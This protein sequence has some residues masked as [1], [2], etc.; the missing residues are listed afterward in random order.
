VSL[1]AHPPASA[2][3]TSATFTYTSSVSGA[4]YQCRLVPLG[5]DVP[6]WGPCDPSGASFTDLAE[7]GYRFDVRARDAADEVSYPAAGWFFRVDTTGPTVAFSSAPA[8]NTRSESATFR[9]EPEELITGSMSCTI[10]GKAIGCANGRVKLPRVATGDHTLTVKA[11]DVA[12]NA[13]T[14]SFDWMVDRTR[15]QV[16]ILDAPNKLSSNPVSAFNLWSNEG[17]GF[18]GCSLDGSPAMPCFGAPN[19][20]NLNEGRHTL[21]VWSVDLAY[22]ESPAITYVWKIDRTPPIVSLVGGPTEGSTSGPGEITFGVSQSEKGQLW[23]SLDG[24]EFSK[25]SSPVRFADLSSGPHTFQ[26]YAV[27]AAGNQSVTVKRTWTIA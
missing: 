5:A 12:G 18:F 20:T 4:G 17:P 24:V 8:I 6:L 3:A 23:C 15:P 25:C 11:T 27:D 13:G 22:N 7:G 19:F 2:A 9:F 21:K 1:G 10:D 26:V 14:T 16:G